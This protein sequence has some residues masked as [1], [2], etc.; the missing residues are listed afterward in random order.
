MVWNH[1]GKQFDCVERKKKKIKKKKKQP[2][3]NMTERTFEGAKH[4]IPHIFMTFSNI[5]FFSKF[6]SFF[7]FNL[8]KRL[9]LSFYYFTPPLLNE[10]K[11]NNNNMHTLIHILN[12]Q[13]DE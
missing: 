9:L 13:R 8:L 2:A 3:T 7:G 10:K 6:I 11:N 1:Q 4:K 12:A 5:Y